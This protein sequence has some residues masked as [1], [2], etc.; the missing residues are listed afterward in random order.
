M[1]FNENKLMNTNRVPFRVFCWIIVGV[2]RVSTQ[3]GEH[4]QSK[5]FVFAYRYF[6]QATI[7]KSVL[8][9]AN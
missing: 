5:T 3:Q 2:R 7:G 1:K 6:T 9:Q 8:L 4:G